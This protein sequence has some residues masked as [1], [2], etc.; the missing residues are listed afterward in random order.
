MVSYNFYLLKWLEE[1]LKEKTNL[2]SLPKTLQKK[3]VSIAN[4]P[5]SFSKRKNKKY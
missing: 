5:G 1:E 4:V 3:K 2:K